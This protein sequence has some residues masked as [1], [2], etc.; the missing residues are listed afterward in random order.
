MWQAIIDSSPDHI[1]LLDRD[2]NIL[3]INHTV[4]DLTKDEVIGKSI[5]DYTPPEFQQVA[6]D[7]IKRV[8]ETGEPDF[9]GAEYHPKEGEAQYFE[10]HVGPVIRS[11]RIV[12]L[13]SNSTNVTQRKQAEEAL[14]EA[15]NE[16]ESRVKART[17]ELQQAVDSL[18][19]EAAERKRAEEALSESLQRFRKVFKDG[20]LGMAIVD[21]DFRLVEVN[22][23]LCKMLGYTR[24]EL[25]ALTFP[26]F[27]HPEDVSI[28]VESAARLF[29]GEILSY[30]VEKRY[31]RKDGKTI[32]G[33]L[34][35]SVVHDEDGNPK[36]GLSMVEDITERVRAEEALRLQVAAIAAAANGIVITDRDGDIV[37]VNPAFSHLTGYTAQEVLGR[38]LR[39]LKSGKQDEQ[40]YK[41]LWD[42][43]LSGQVWRGEIV[44]LRKDGGLYTEEQTITPVRD[45]R[46]AIS[47]FIAIKQDV[48]ERKRAEEALRESEETF[49]TLFELASDALLTVLLPDGTI[50]DANL[51]ATELLG[52]S[53]DE[54]LGLAGR[55]DIIAPEVLEQ[56][57]QEWQTQ[58]EENGRF[59][60]ETLWVRKD[61]TRIPV[62]VSGTTV[63]VRGQLHFQLIGHDITER[64]KA[65]EALHEARGALEGRVERQMVR[66]NPY[67]LTFRE[68][69]VLHHIASGKANKEIA[70]EL[71][72]SPL[73]VHK[74]V[75]NI[76]GKMDAASRTEAASRALREGLLD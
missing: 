51:A 53:R 54:L 30:Q 20:P 11:G 9:Y 6:A 59:S 75:A 48:T 15:H 4:P 61:G 27:T 38:N 64:K 44:N 49:R 31:I 19:S 52:Y 60:V 1:I 72:I 40:L 41:Q 71:G 45:E 28:D 7:C 22:Q 39:I 35:T 62:V 63:E 24:K 57:D 42:T 47:H 66:R 14:R 36:Y 16:L 21:L 12:A 26:E 69:T 25:A 37:S 76:L 74:H 50:I 68:F 18:R 34:H 65:E 13:V 3:F 10:I 43:I 17:V 32:W 70:H 67:G 33:L 2:A 58:I 55:L 5:Y 29:R 23:K 46:G 8:L 56:T 73:T